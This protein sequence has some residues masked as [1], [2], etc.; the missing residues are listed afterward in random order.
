MVASVAVL[1]SWEI[2][3]NLVRAGLLWSDAVIHERESG[4]AVMSFVFLHVR[5][6]FTEMMAM[7]RAAVFCW[8]VRVMR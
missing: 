4:S 3:M 2:S 6:L 5:R 7:A 1:T 8:L